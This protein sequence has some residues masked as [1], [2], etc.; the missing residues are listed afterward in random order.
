MNRL[1]K[2]YQKEICPALIKKFK[3]SSPVMVP[4]VTKVVINQ[5]MGHFAKDGKL[6][7]VGLQELALITGQKAIKTIAK[8]SIAAFKLRE[9]QVMGGKV[10]LRGVK[11]YQFLD[12]L[13]NVSLARIRDFR[14]LSPKAFD[15][16]GNYSLGVKEQIIFPEIDYDKVKKVNGLDINIITT[17]KTQEEAQELLTL[18]GLPFREN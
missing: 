1:V 18:M 10:T 13:F 4:K 2:K 9:G 15:G 3:Y 5:A 6:I 7:E 16:Q 14:G 12:K 11:M 8:K 17:A